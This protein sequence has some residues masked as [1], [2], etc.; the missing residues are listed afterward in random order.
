[1]APP[2]HVQAFH[3]SQPYGG[4]LLPGQAMPTSMRPA[5]PLA[6]SGVVVSATQ[7][8]DP[9]VQQLGADLHHFAS[10]LMATNGSFAA[11]V[12]DAT[13]GGQLPLRVV[14]GPVSGS[15]VGEWDP[16]R[17][18]LTLDPNH[19]NV[20]DVGRLQGALAFEMIN[21]AS[22]QRL[23]QINDAAR[24]GQFEQQAQA[25]NAAHPHQPI[26]P[27]FLYAEAVEHLE[28]QNGRLHHDVL[29]QAQAS[30]V[31]IPPSADLFSAQFGP[32]AQALGLNSFGAYMN[33][34]MQPVNGQPPHIQSYIEQYGI[35]RPAP[36]QIGPEQQ[37]Y[38]DHMAQLRQNMHQPAPGGGSAQD[39][40][41][42]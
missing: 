9:E 11:V 7:S 6:S 34:Q 13:Q 32:A 8:A 1:M 29:A 18:T 38:L 30:G 21:A 2:Q 12:R 3:P 35:H 27:A 42:S 16:S 33:L 17:R 36:V 5:D 40:F 31:H 41:N 25:H 23:E 15:G 10:N 22:T 24:Y 19:P 28:F 39:Y 26:T 20:H 14:L 37:A 4:Q